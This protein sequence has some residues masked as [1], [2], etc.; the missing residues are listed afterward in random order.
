[1]LPDLQVMQLVYERERQAD[2]WE[3]NA[4]HRTE[5]AM[6]ELAAK[7]TEERPARSRI[8]RLLGRVRRAE[9]SV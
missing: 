1:M 4:R 6:Q 9:G 5:L 2:E 3:R 7:T 8:G